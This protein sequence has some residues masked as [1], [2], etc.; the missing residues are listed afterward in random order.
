[1]LLRLDIQFFAGEKTEKATPKKRED[2][3]K[4]GKVAKSQD[5]NTAIL[6]LACFMVLMVFAPFMKDGMVSLY[7]HTFTERI[8]WE[9]TEHS[10]HQIFS[11][12]AMDA[13]KIIAP[14]ALIAIVA[15]LASNLMQIG[16]LFTSEPL[17]FDLKKIDPIQGAKRIFSIRA[18][19]ELLKSLLKIVCIGVVTFA[20]IWIYKDDMMMMAFKSVDSSLAFFGKTMLIMGI[21]A[22]IALLFLAVFDYAYQRFDYEK[23]MRMSKQ[24]IRDEHKNIEGDPLIKSKIK[25]KQRQ[26]AMRRMMSEVPTADVI[27][28]NP[29]HYAI[30]V[31]YDEAISSAPYVVAKGVDLTAQKI[32]E[33]AK[34]HQ[35]MTVENRPLARS[36]YAQVE[37]GE[38]IPEQ[39]Y[40]AI[41]EILAYVYRL[42]R[43][44]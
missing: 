1:M 26:M 8:N 18:L 16:F 11:G 20:V 25:E 10:V 6:L 38:A 2:E 12:A 30:A 22:T 33:V 3:R 43:K 7:Y 29:T 27:I 37:I 28:T 19:V 5:V 36:L 23:N 14:I 9:V 39:F 41:A 32:K 15:G 35:I 24:D 31:K 42:E 17:K 34:A 21:A 4:K 40:Q 44:V 13:A